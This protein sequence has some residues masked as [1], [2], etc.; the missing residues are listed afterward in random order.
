M[1]PKKDLLISHLYKV[2]KS[3][4]QVWTPTGPTAWSTTNV[5]VF[6]SST[7]THRNSLHFFHPD[8]P[9]EVTVTH[10]PHTAIIYK[11]SFDGKGTLLCVID[12]HSKIS[13]WQMQG[14]IINDWQLVQVTDQNDSLCVSVDTQPVICFSWTNIG[15]NYVRKSWAVRSE[16]VSSYWTTKFSMEGPSTLLKSKIF[17]TSVITVTSRG[18]LSLITPSKKVRT[19]YLPITN[20]QTADIVVYIVSGKTYAD[21]ATVDLM[22]TLRLYTVEIMTS[23]IKFVLS[24]LVHLAPDSPDTRILSLKFDN[25]LSSDS[26]LFIAVQDPEGGRIEKWKFTQTSVS[27]NPVLCGNMNTSDSS[28][29]LHWEKQHSTS[30]SSV[31]DSLRVPFLPYS[32]PTQTD[33]INNRIGRTVAVSCKDG[34]IL[35]LD[36]NNLSHV[37]VISSE[38][39]KADEDEEKKESE[40]ERK[41]KINFTF[42]PAGCCLAVLANE[43]VS[44][45]S[46]RNSDFETESETVW[47]TSVLEHCILNNWDHWEIMSVASR[48]DEM[49]SRLEITLN[50]SFDA[51]NPEIR[52]LYFSRMMSIKMMLYKLQPHTSHWPGQLWCCLF[53][54]CLADKL[55]SLL[56]VDVVNNFVCPPDIE[57]N[58]LVNMVDSKQFQLSEQILLS[59]Q[60]LFQWVLDYAQL[61]SICVQPQK[62]T[63]SA[64]NW[65]S[66]VTDGKTLNNLRELLGYIKIWATLYPRC[67]PIICGA[68]SSDFSTIFK[69]V[70]MLVKQFPCKNDIP[71]SDY[72]TIQ[73]FQQ[74]LTTLPRVV[75]TALSESAASTTP[76]QYHFQFE[77]NSIKCATM[78]CERPALPLSKINSVINSSDRDMIRN[79]VLSAH[80]L[81]LKQDF[82]KECVVCGCV[83]T[84]QPP[85]HQ[86]DWWVRWKHSC[87]CGGS[88]KKPSV[89]A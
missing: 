13:I 34:S 29:K 64:V 55:K 56:P 22:C 77:P 85:A 84:L 31:P 1:K 66:V 61:I 18:L 67:G 14:H 23:N 3:G 60:P 70:S 9:W 21:I 69:A 32:V 15:L 74:K 87:V 30:I 49:L 63:S 82:V 28:V 54:N 35:I 75:I 41:S 10:T 26:D 58:S 7:A 42:S 4:D 25:S 16:D 73:L 88:W 83:T 12:A 20:M 27:L 19:S 68:E 81:H 44:V 6:S 78:L 46:F 24:R 48:R 59:H 39:L 45:F 17:E 79:T 72:D 40:S 57:I 76:I 47:L 65:Q 5:I 2:S 71:S 89:L 36:R 86:L 8:T 33:P 53:L 11:L 80:S 37:D 51:Q 43:V 50:R 52:Q 62:R 38:Q